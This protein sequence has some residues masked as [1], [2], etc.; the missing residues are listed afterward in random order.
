MAVIAAALFFSASPVAVNVP[1][2]TP[3]IFRVVVSATPSV[4]AVAL[5]T[6]V[7]FTVAVT[8]V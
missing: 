3:L 2:S 7:A 1:I 4:A 8:P 6:S 5:V